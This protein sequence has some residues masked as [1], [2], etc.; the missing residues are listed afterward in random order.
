MLQ[1]KV[2]KNNEKLFLFHVKTS[3]LSQETFYPDCF[4]HVGKWLDKKAK[5][6]FEI[7]EVRDWDP[8]NYNTHTA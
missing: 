6:N 5:V 2:F 1:W 4:D 7:C 8:N 3:F